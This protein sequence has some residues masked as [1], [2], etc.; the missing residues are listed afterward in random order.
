MQGQISNTMI[1]V[2]DI[3]KSFKDVKA[4][5]KVSLKIDYGESV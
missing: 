4:L 1:E 3:T 2:I 5:D